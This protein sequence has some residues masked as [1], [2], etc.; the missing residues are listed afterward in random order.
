LKFNTS[1]EAP[2]LAPIV[3]N[4]FVPSI[5]NQPPRDRLMIQQIDLLYGKTCWTVRLFPF[6]MIQIKGL[7][8]SNLPLFIQFLVLLCMNFDHAILWGI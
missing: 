3:A 8:P 7:Q 2:F 4:N 6:S 1:I 5:R